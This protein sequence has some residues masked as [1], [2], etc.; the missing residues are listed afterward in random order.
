MKLNVFVL[1]LMASVVVGYPQKPDRS[2]I[3]KVTGLQE[4][5]RIAQ[6]GI[7]FRRPRLSPDGRWIALTSVSP[8]YAL[9][10]ASMDDL[11]PRLLAKREDLAKV[12]QYSWS[13]DSQQIAYVDGRT[14]RLINVI[15][16][17][18]TSY[19]TVSP[20][21]SDPVFNAEGS[22]AFVANT[23][24]IGNQVALEGDV[25]KVKAMTPKDR[26]YLEVVSPNGKKQVIGDSAQLGGENIIVPYIFSPGGEVYLN[27]NGEDR[28]ITPVK[29]ISQS[30]IACLHAVLSPD[31]RKVAMEC[32]GTTLFVYEILSEKK[33]VVG[34]GT[35]GM[36]PCWSPDSEWIL[37]LVSVEDGHVVFATDLYIS[38]YTGGRTVKLIRAKGWVHGVSWSK[39]NLIAYEQEGKIIVGKISMN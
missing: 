11:K 20:F 5:G 16:K 15:T 1:I 27:I 25:E 33:H 13:P 14:V 35:V 34:Q 21:M 24:L 2:F 4:I 18:V 26:P 37:F 10:I 39:D 8:E 36:T 6:E 3:D 17:K 30:T 29:R 23:N 38:H 22:V 28:R 32:V 19:T 7:E 31:K 12:R 9:W